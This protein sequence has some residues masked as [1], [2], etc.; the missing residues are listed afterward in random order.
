MSRFASRMVKH[1]RAD[2]RVARRVRSFLPSL[3][4]IGNWQCSRLFRDIPVRQWP[5]Q[6]SP[7]CIPEAFTECFLVSV[8]KS[9][10]G[11]RL[12]YYFDGYHHR[13]ILTEG[14]F[15]SQ[16]LISVA[17]SSRGMAGNCLVGR[18]FV[19]QKP[20]N[21]ALLI[22]VADHGAGT[23][24][25]V[26][27]GSFSRIG[28][29]VEGHLEDE[30]SLRDDF[31]NG[32]ELELMTLTSPTPRLVFP[33]RIFLFSLWQGASVFC[34]SSCTFVNEVV[35]RVSSCTVVLFLEPQYEGIIW[36]IDFWQSCKKYILLGL[37]INQWLC[38]IEK[39]R[40][41]TPIEQTQ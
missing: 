36:K 7:G 5:L 31:L 35:C 18:L 27:C 14:R 8:D 39:P 23:D 38:G 6:L 33:R 25:R 34:D 2:G 26:L 11:E 30:V 17:R 24:C 21:C 15:A 41:K 32:N 19:Q 40:F 9:L 22:G 12:R 1:Q 4:G 37:F 16:V 3:L 29:A 10:V 28:I 20:Q 13:H